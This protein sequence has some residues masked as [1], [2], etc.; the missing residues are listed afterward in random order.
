M[1]KR[2]WRSW[3]YANERSRFWKS[4]RMELC[5]S[6]LYNSSTVGWVRVC[7]CGS[8]R[9]TLL[10]S[11]SATFFSFVHYPLLTSYLSHL[12]LYAKETS[13]CDWHNWLRK[14]KEWWIKECIHSFFYYFGR[15]G[16]WSI[17]DASSCN[18]IQSKFKHIQ[19]HLYSLWIWCPKRSYGVFI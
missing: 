5:I 2:S 4:A 16:D 17:H 11:P 12:W 15:V 14:R 3:L 1:T 10:S 6:Q 7:T 13:W 18:I 9:V 19:L 8:P